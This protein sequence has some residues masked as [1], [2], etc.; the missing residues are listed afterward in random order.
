MVSPHHVTLVCT[1][2]FPH[3]NK[4]FPEDFGC[5]PSKYVDRFTHI[6]TR[7]NQIV[8]L[9]YHTST[10]QTNKQLEVVVE[11]NANKTDPQTVLA[12]I[13]EICHQKQTASLKL[14]KVSKAY[15]K[16]YGYYKNFC[17]DCAHLFQEC[18][19]LKTAE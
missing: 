16:Q 6:F 17:V 2:H 18:H 3:T 13:C 9:V 15:T 1:E 11:A 19:F 12:R 10:S 7:N 8:Q 4:H 5:K 14:S